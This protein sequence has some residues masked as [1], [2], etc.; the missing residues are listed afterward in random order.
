[1]GAKSTSMEPH[2]INRNPIRPP[3]PVGLQIAYFAMGC[4]WGAERLF[5]K[6]PGVFS[7][8][9]GYTGGHVQNPTYERVCSGNTGHAE[10]VQVVYNPQLVTYDSLLQAFWNNH[11]PTTLN[12]QGNDIGSQ[13]RSAIFFT[14]PE[15]QTQAEAS[16]TRYQ[17]VLGQRSIVTEIE[18][19]GEF[20]YAEDYHQQYLG[21]N[22]D[23]YCGLAGLDV[24]CPQEGL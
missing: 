4:F 21:K 7:T 18:P 17:A 5:W 19:A 16:K 13:Y 9:V 15:Q 3:F 20:Y 24:K 8:A 2:F 14:T 6:M 10:T 23:G 1:M 12:R 11:N 22:P